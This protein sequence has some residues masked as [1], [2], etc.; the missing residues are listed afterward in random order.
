MLWCWQ[1]LWSSKQLKTLARFSMI[2]MMKR[3][4]LIIINILRL[5]FFSIK[6]QKRIKS[7]TQTTLDTN[8][9]NVSKWKTAILSLNYQKSILKIRGSF[10]KFYVKGGSTTI[11]DDQIPFFSSLNTTRKQL[12]ANMIIR[13]TLNCAKFQQNQ[14]YSLSTLN[15]IQITIFIWRRGEKDKLK[16]RCC[17]PN[18]NGRS[19]SNF[20]KRIIPLCC[21][22]FSNEGEGS[23]LKFV[24]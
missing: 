8:K 15:P 1:N 23:S 24:A 12:N 10:R 21:C 9:L 18:N 19:Q 20:Q 3:Q 6:T 14:I 22:L 5:T 11:V 13:Q 17:H 2:S 16:K 4:S 7:P